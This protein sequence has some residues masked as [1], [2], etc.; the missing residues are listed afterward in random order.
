[1]E[2]NPYCAPASHFDVPE[3]T[4]LSLWNPVAAVWWSLLFTPVFGSVVQ[5]K[6]WHAL[7]EHEKAGQAMIWSVSMAAVLIV[8]S[9]ISALNPALSRIGNLTGLLVMVLWYVACA[10]EQI[11]YVALKGA[12]SRR[13]WGMPILGALGGFFALGM[14]VL[15]WASDF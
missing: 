5:M 9:I 3:S 7:G 6:N 1:M 15:V 11:D 12:Y 13:G 2:M 4:S 8:A 10:R 14:L